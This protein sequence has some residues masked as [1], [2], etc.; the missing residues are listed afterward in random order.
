MAVGKEIKETCV[1]K[2]GS[3]GYTCVIGKTDTTDVLM[4]RLE[5]CE[6]EGSVKPSGGSYSDL[7]IS[8]AA[9]A[10]DDGHSPIHT[11]TPRRQFRFRVEN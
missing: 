11:P 7:H 3:A 5:N 9:M 6:G 4:H 2:E 10:E 1:K 8:M